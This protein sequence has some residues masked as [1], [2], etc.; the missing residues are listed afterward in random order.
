MVNAPR[1]YHIDGKAGF[2]AI[3]A[4]EPPVLDSASA[5]ERSMINL[6]APA[7]CIPGK[8]LARILKTMDLRGSQEHPFQRRC[9]ALWIVDLLCI[10]HPDVYGSVVFAPRRPECNRSKADF[11][12]G[13]PLQLAASA[14]DMDHLHARNGLHGHLLPKKVR[15]GFAVPSFARNAP[16]ALVH[17]DF[18]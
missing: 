1:N 10:H 7:F 11:K 15:F 8:S 5:L 2:K 17:P 14:G 3:G 12:L 9:D 16:K 6:D 18:L 13:F 4:V